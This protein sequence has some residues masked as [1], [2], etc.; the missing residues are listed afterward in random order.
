MKSKVF[1]NILSTIVSF[2][3]N[4][5]VETDVSIEQTSKGPMSL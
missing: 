1:S 5:T 2:E 4:K 3:M